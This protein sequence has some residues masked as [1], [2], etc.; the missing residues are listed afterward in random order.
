MKEQKPTKET[1]IE[2]LGSVKNPNV[3]N[4]LQRR[5]G[6]ELAQGT[7]Q[8]TIVV[9]EEI[10]FITPPPVKERKRPRYAKKGEK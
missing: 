2:S 4:N 1:T 5:I 3:L 8:M 7:G 9:G 6:E 10:K